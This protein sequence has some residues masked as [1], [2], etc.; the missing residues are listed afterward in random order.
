MKT[1]IVALLGLG[2][3]MFDS[4]LG[5]WSK[6]ANPGEDFQSLTFSQDT[7]FAVGSG[8]RVFI[9]TDMGDTWLNQY[10]DN[11]TRYLV[12]LTYCKVASLPSPGG[13]LVGASKGKIVHSQYGQ[14]WSSW[15]TTGSD[16]IVAFAYSRSKNKVTILAGG[17][18][19]GIR[20]YDLPTHSWLPSDSGLS[21]LN[22]S[23]L[24][25]GPYV[26]DSSAQAV[27]A[28]TYGGGVFLSSDNGQTWVPRNEDMWESAHQCCGGV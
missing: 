16:D 20:I 27:F 19:G 14:D 11:P 9:S 15:D 25:T 8:A 12:A 6:I 17:F 28:G 1:F 5:Q 18:G 13:Y 21:N 4:G 22:V 3:V 23:S 10:P 7:L 26:P 24:T 2:C